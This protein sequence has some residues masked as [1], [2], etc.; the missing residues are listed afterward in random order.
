MLT[1][2]L[3]RAYRRQG[4][5]K[6][7]QWRGDARERALEIGEQLIEIAE[8][9]VGTTRGEL[10]DAFGAV[11]VSSRDQRVADGLKKLVLDRCD[12]EVDTSIDPP[13]L[14]DEVF[15]RAAEA[16]RAATQRE[17]FDRDAILAEVAADK[18][19]SAEEIERLLYADIKRN[20]RLLHF[21]P[22]GAEALLD[23]YD[24]QQVQAVLLRAER[25]VAEVSCAH[26]GTTRALFRTLKF[27][28]LLHRIEKLD[29]G[30][31]RITIDGPLSLF[32]AGTKYGLQLALAFPAIRACDRWAL[33]ADVRWGKDRARVRF[34][35]EGSREELPGD[36]RL[37]D[38]V[39][40]LRAKCAERYGKGKSA[41]SVAP[42]SDVLSLPGVGECVPD[43]A[44]EKDGTRVLLEVLGYWSRDAV[45]KRVELAE[46][47]L[48]VPIVFALSSRLRVSEE[49]LPDE[50]PAAL[51]VYKGVMSPKAVLEK[52]DAVASRR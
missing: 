14:R 38:E 8:R 19:V 36:A 6:L 52:I 34:S 46:A 17:D 50:V 48:E 37:P 2:D 18:G 33:S 22:V 45:W 5:L 1:A 11:A 25:V 41:W 4:E 26:A 40:T 24:R 23:D 3:V 43:L 30:R 29:R 27:H 28:R 12:F 49:V 51:Y 16:R 21:E 13:A 31:H 9:E 47:G 7:R 32:G 44:F 39:E 20:H 15:R 35:A 10:M 42:A